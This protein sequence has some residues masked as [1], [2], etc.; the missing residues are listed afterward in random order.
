M[1]TDELPPMPDAVSHAAGDNT[2]L[3]YTA[4]Q[5]RAYGQQCS[6][7][8]LREAAELCDKHAAEWPQSIAALLRAKVKE[9]I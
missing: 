8:A 9:R 4:E 1:T 5:M 2:R 6:N 7:A 3:Y